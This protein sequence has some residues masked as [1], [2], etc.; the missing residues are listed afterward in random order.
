[1]LKDT[2]SDPTGSELETEVIRELSMPAKIEVSK[3]E[4]LEADDPSE[5]YELKSPMVSYSFDKA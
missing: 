5:A 4:D 2:S 3:I 1:M